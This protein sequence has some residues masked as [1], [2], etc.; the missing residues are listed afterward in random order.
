ML[1]R[2]MARKY[3]G[4]DD[5]VG[6]VLEMDRKTPLRVGAVIEDLPTNTHLELGIVGVAGP[7]FSRVNGRTPT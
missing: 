3:F 2:S 6:G 7:D 4:R 5:P 1:T